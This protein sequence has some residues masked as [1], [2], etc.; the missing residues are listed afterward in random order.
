MIRW[1]KTL[2]SAIAVSTV[3]V[4]CSSSN[5]DP[6]QN[7]AQIAENDPQFS[8]LS[9][10]LKSTE[11][12]A[13]LSGAGPFTVF[14]PTDEAFVAFLDELGQRPGFEG[15]SLEDLLSPAARPLVSEVLTYHVLAGQV[16]RAEVPSGR[17][18]DTVQGARFRVDPI[19]SDL[20]ITDAVGRT[21]KIVSTD[22]RATNGVIHVIDKVILPRLPDEDDRPTQNIVE[23]AESDPRFTILTQL[24]EAT[25]LD[26]ALSGAG[27]FTV[28]APTDEAFANLL[29]ELGVGSLEELLAVEGIV[30]LVADLLRYHVV[31]CQVLR[32]QVPTGTP[33][34]TLLEGYS[35]E[36]NRV[37]SNLVITDGQPRTSTIIQT[38]IRATNGVIHVID[39]VILPESPENG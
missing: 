22:V 26:A 39:T 25:G 37:G 29:G 1:F 9:Q 16:L 32:A 38:N 15:V 10:L 8:I 12:D 7:I 4:A 3:L 17:S 36:V 14:A 34:P 24:L 31:S 5:D 20:V 2:L 13:D 23:I 33:I 18:I 11:L 30:D 35:F 28:F 27:P 6:S 21:S 19:G